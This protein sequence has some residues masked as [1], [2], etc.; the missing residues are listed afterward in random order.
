MNVDNIVSFVSN[1]ENGEYQ[2]LTLFN[3]FKEFT[4]A[5]GYTDKR[6]YN[7]FAK[8]IKR[9]IEKQDCG[10]FKEK[11]KDENGKRACGYFVEHKFHE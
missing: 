3:M 5:R 8:D 6:T 4:Q 11:I 7:T 9:E 10:V 2:T 1:L